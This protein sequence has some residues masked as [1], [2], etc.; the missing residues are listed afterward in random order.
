MQAQAWGVCGGLSLSPGALNWGVVLLALSKK[1]SG[2]LLGS[3]ES[4]AGVWVLVGWAEAAVDSPLF[5]LGMSLQ[6][7]LQG[8]VWE[9]RDC[10]KANTPQRGRDEEEERGEKGR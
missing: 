4:G 9:G 8:D 10:Y 1:N 6:S 7:S 3:G 2:S 5:L